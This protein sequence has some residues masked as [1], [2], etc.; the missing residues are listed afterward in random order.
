[1]ACR[2][3]KKMMTE[4]LSP[5]GNMDSAMA[6][7]NAGADAI[8]VGGKNFS[9]RNLAQN[10]SDEELENLIDC[11]AVRGVKVYIAV[12]T[13]YKDDEL[14]QVLAFVCKM[15]AAGASAFILQDAGLAQVLKNHL[16]EIE[17]HAST[18]MTVHSV[19]GAKYM[20]RLGFSR[21]V[22]AR[23]LSLQEI[24]EIKAGADIELEVFVH[25]ALCYAYSGQ[26][27]MSSLIGGRSGNRGKCAQI[28]RTKF[29]L[30]QN[31]TEKQKGYLL[32]PKDIS[33]LD[34]LK[35][36]TDAGVTS[37]KIEG[38]MKSPEYVHLVTKAYKVMLEQGRVDET[39]K[40]NLLQIFNR[41]GEFTEGFY[42]T[43]AS[44]D[45]M[46]TITPKSS[47]TKVGK[48]V[49]ASK[50][51]CTIQFTAPVCPGDGIE[52]WTTGGNHAGTGISKEIAAGATENFSIEGHITEG[53]PVYKSYDKRLVDETTREMLSATRKQNIYCDV[54]AVEG[55]KF[56]LTI[57]G[58][59]NACGNIVEKAKNAPV[60]KEELLT[61]L[62]KTGNTPFA[63]IF[64]NVDVG[65]DIFISKGEI[66]ALRRQ[67]LE[68]LEKKM[69]DK[70]KRP[71]PCV[72]LR[73]QSIAQPAKQ[74]L[75]VEISDITQLPAVLGAG[76]DRVYVPLTNE[77]IFAQAMLCKNPTIDTTGTEIFM[78]LPYI[79][80]NKTED[81]IKTLL[82]VLENSNITGYLVR[83]W[84]QL[85]LLK[86][87]CKKIMLDSTFNIFNSYAA[88]A[89]AEYEIT[90]SQELNLK[91]IKEMGNRN[92]EL[93]VYGRQNM[94]FTHNCPVGLYGSACGVERFHPKRQNICSYVLK[95]KLGVEFPVVTDCKNC[96]TRILNS[97]IL[98]TAPKFAGL[99]NTNASSFRLVFTTENEDEI[100]QTIARYKKV[101]VGEAIQ[102]L[103]D[104]TYGHYFRGVE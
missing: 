27:L 20:E 13:L 68:T 78:A 97:K 86:S 60:K 57:N 41:G 50:G 74:K 51:R 17:L 19:H 44:P 84:G 62:S 18:Q 47:G 91:E 79:C 95:D 24:K 15:Y 21:V 10:F 33:T 25:G 59:I 3:P 104:A 2:K 26:C 70:I 49:S 96:V 5:A 64:G 67:A 45:M 53:N 55:K 58:N 89:F 38:R 35:D 6:A 39:V 36:I 102:G 52:I 46:S 88:E 34:I 80:R 77:R 56:Q 16:P 76:V 32:S 93:I 92:F 100:I 90:L 98:D 40:H 1:M 9:A 75:H 81:E 71:L 65:E 85:E 30:L 23:E 37:L 101:L 11:A 22:L 31:G 14:P 7:I 66:N 43:Y 48:V 82:P 29:S 28:C 83:T 8:Y 54:E 69:L 87:S 4:L 12:N 103:E 73:K 94:M 72:E 61:Q 99:K 63:F 42:N